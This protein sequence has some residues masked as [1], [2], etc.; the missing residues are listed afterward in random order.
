MTEQPTRRQFLKMLGIAAAGLSL[1]VPA[2]GQWGFGSEITSRLPHPELSTN[3][4]VLFQRF[5]FNSYKSYLEEMSPFIGMSLE[6]VFDIWG[7]HPST[8]TS[9][10]NEYQEG[11]LGVVPPHITSEL[12]NRDESI[13][14][15]VGEHHDSLLQK[16]FERWAEGQMLKPA[17][18]FVHLDTHL[19]CN[20][21]VLPEGHTAVT[22]FNPRMAVAEDMIQT[23]QQRGLLAQ[24]H[25]GV[26]SWL[27]HLTNLNMLR[28]GGTILFCGDYP[29]VGPEVGFAPVSNRGAPTSEQDVK[30]LVSYHVKVEDDDYLVP[31]A[32][33]E[34]QYQQLVVQGSELTIFVQIGTNQQQRASIQSF[35]YATMRFLRTHKEIELLQRAPD[36][37]FWSTLQEVLLEFNNP[38]LRISID[39]DYLNRGATR[40]FRARTAEGPVVMTVGNEFPDDIGEYWEAMGGFFSKRW[41]IHDIFMA[42]SIGWTPQ[43]SRQDPRVSADRIVLE[44]LKWIQT[45]LK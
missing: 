42:L 17:D 23:S 10:R 39:V 11:I 21:T 30:F 24:D 36:P 6:E 19:D 31:V 1:P 26:A 15:F 12:N 35:T 41:N 16:W 7:P 22:A 37:L 45:G 44:H 2:L 4:D 25:I 34:H 38:E 27:G 3:L 9:V 5:G 18:V 13:P 20:A 43:R 33:T 28:S 14:V 32:M 8:A 29:G 40:G